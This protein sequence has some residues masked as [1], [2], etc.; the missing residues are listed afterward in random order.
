[1][2]ANTAYLSK[3]RG[4][5]PLDRWAVPFGRWALIIDRLRQGT[6]VAAREGIATTEDTAT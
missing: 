1:M 6:L 2:Q 4:G 5:D 3:S